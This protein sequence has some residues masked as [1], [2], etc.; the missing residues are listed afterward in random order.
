MLGEMEIAMKSDNKIDSHDLAKRIRLHGLDMVH[1]AGASHIG[2]ILSVSDIIAVLYADILNYDASNP[3]WDERDRFVLS[4]GHAGVAVYACLAECGFFDKSLLNTYGDNGSIFSC[5][6]SH[7][8]VPGV[9]V[10]TGSLGH[11]CGM[12]CGIALHGKL[13]QKE[14]NVYTVIGDGECNEGSVWEMA[15]LASQYGLD[16]FTVI[17][18][19]N[20]MQAMGFTRDVINMA[21]LSD[22]WKSFGWDAIEVEGHNHDALRKALLERHEGKPKVLIAHTVKGK[23]VSFMENELLWHY[24]D[25]QGSYY[26]DAKKELE[27]GYVAKENN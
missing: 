21:P 9:E 11:G 27:E 8:I 17:V 19:N 10:S 4:K 26:E 3:E 18:D 15:M 6:A 5:H 13:K 14:Y 7:R 1:H 16:N 12:A 24:R 25:P 20:G 23:G 2:S 22:K